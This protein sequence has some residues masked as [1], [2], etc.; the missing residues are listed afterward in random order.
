MDD[1]KYKYL[2]NAKV[3]TNRTENLKV[4]NEGV[5]SS[6]RAA[7]QGQDYDP[8]VHGGSLF[9]WAAHGLVSKAKQNAIKNKYNKTLNDFVQ[10]VIQNN[11]ANAQVELSSKLKQFTLYP[12]ANQK[13]P[14]QSK[15]W[16]KHLILDLFDILNKS[17]N[18]G[19]TIPATPV[20]KGGVLSR[21]GSKIKNAF[22]TPRQNPSATVPTYMHNSRLRE[23]VETLL[24]ADYLIETKKLNKN[25][26]VPGTGLTR[27]ETNRQY[28]GTSLQP[29]EI[30]NRE[31]Q[32]RA[33]PASGMETQFNTS[34]G[35]NPSQ[36]PQPQ[37]QPQAQQ[38]ANTVVDPNTIKSIIGVLTKHPIWK[39][40]GGWTEPG[41]GVSGISPAQVFTDLGF[42]NISNSDDLI[43]KL[44]IKNQKL[45]DAIDIAN[46]QNDKEASD[47]RKMQ[48]NTL[49]HDIVSV[50]N[51]KENSDKKENNDAFINSIK[52][53]KKIVP[54]KTIL[55]KIQSVNTD[56]IDRAKQAYEAHRASRGA[57]GPAGTQNRTE[58][59]AN[60]SEYNSIFN[61]L[62][63]DDFKDFL[64]NYNKHILTSAKE[65][66]GKGENGVAWE[67]V[68]KNDVTNQSSK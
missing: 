64:T 24:D 12:D 50:F 8:S 44:D 58:R 9:S 46:N 15:S 55:S 68:T 45:K 37:P 6:I 25:Q 43:A 21:I 35:V 27:R 16:I 22:N 20:N 53:L 66:I 52:Q 30:L 48:L 38:N 26:R 39:T 23:Y 40:V 49:F 36:Q 61:K 65:L 13:K 51:E 18:S 41:V 19:I 10:S 31:A 3:A 63:F 4:L 42:D 5:F 7:N 57:R 33:R 14:E 67:N 32:G 56:M 11:G 47:Q 62:L 2:K 1:L 17:K 28:Q 54:D 59:S 34:P 29:K 60:A